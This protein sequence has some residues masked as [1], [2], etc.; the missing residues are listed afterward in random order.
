M[1]APRRSMRRRPP[2]G[3]LADLSN[4]SCAQRQ[5]RLQ[6]PRRGVD[7]AKFLSAFGQVRFARPRIIAQMP[8]PLPAVRRGAATAIMTE[9]QPAIFFG[10]GSPIIA[11]EENETTRS[12]RRTAASFARPRA[13]LCISAHWLTRGVQATGQAQPPTVHDFGAFPRAMFEI[14][15]PAPGDPAL[16]RRVAELIEPE[17]LR[18][19]LDWGFDHGCWT[20]LMKAWPEAEI[21]VV[22]LSL[23]VTRSAREHFELGRRLRPLRD[24]GVLI[25][26]S[27][28]IVHNLGVLVRTP[29]ATPHRFAESFGE[30]IRAAVA[31]DEP[32]TVINFDRLGRDAEL[33]VPTP[34]HFWPLLYVLGARHPDDQP[35]FEPSYVQYGSVD[36]TT[37]TLRP[38]CAA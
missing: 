11:L 30:V 7:F 12:W 28:N 14:R 17:P 36:M 18:S 3:R 27:G 35:V 20:V 22:Q 1:R 4:G 19:S 6:A 24:E 8:P 9:R 13:I 32:E 2:G 23:D 37:I 21:P 25:M 34:D 15:Y 16:C 29:E 31:A 5:M 33:S 38:A 10:H 26:G